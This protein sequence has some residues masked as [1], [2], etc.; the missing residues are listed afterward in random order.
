M[1]IRKKSSIYKKSY[2]LYGQISFFGKDNLNF[3]AVTLA[4]TQRYINLCKKFRLKKIILQKN[5]HLP[6]FE[7]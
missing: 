6:Y 1:T 7:I 4:K 3:K 5:M 2:E